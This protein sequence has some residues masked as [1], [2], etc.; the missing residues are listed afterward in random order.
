MACTI[1][2]ALT[3]GAL[4]GL[5]LIVLQCRFVYSESV[6]EQDVRDKECIGEQ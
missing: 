3:N 4:A 2:R 6:T 5:E 1:I